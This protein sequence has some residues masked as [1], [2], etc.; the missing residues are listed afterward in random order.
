MQTRK[1]LKSF[2]KG[3]AIAD[4]VSPGGPLAQNAEWLLKAYNE[5]QEGVRVA[6]K[7]HAIA[8]VQPV[9]QAARN[10][11]D[12]MM[13]DR[14]L[15]DDT[16]IV[17]RFDAFSVIKDATR[18][19]KDDMSLRKLALH[20]ERLWHKDPLGYLSAGAMSRL[21]DH[22]QQMS[23]R[24]VVAE[25][26]DVTIPKV[27]FTNLPVATLVR[28]ASQ[29]ENQSDFDNAIA[30]NCLQGDDLKSVRARIFIRA[31]VNRKDAQAGPTLPSSGSMTVADKPNICATHGEPE[32]TLCSRKK[33]GKDIASRIANR[34]YKMA[35]PDPDKD[36]A[37]ECDKD[38]EK[39][40]ELGI[41]GSGMMEAQAQTKKGESD[42][43][44]CVEFEPDVNEQQ[45]PQ[46][47]VSEDD[48]SQVLTED[49]D[50]KQDRAKMK[51]AITASH[52][53]VDDGMNHFPINNDKF[54]QLSLKI[55][56][57]MTEV[58]T[59]W[60]GSLE[61]LKQTVRD[62][63]EKD[64]GKL[65]PGLAKFKFDKKKDKGKGKPK[66][67]FARTT[68]MVEEALVKDQQYKAAGYTIT[69][70]ANDIVN[71]VSKTGTKKYQMID[72][73][74]AITDFLYLANTTKHPAGE[75]PPPVF[76]IREGLR[77]ACP[78]CHEVNSYEMPKTAEDLSCG[79]CHA[80]IPS[81]AITAAMEVGAI[82][83]ESTLVA[84]TPIDLQDEFAAKFAKAAEIMNADV[85]T[86]GCRSEAYADGRDEVVLAKV[87]DYMVDAGYKPIQIQGQ[88]DMPS[89]DTTM[90]SSDTEMPSAEPKAQEAGAIPTPAPTTQT[91][92]EEVIKSA[93]THYKHMGMNPVEAVVQ[94]KKDYGDK[95]DEEGNPISH[96]Y[97]P[98]LVVK[99]ASEV[100]G[101]DHA[102]LDDYMALTP[103]T[104]LPKAGSAKQ[105]DIPTPKVNQ[106]QPDAVTPE[107]LGP[108]SDTKGEV[109]M[110]GKIKTQ[111]DPQGTFAD[112]GTE[113]DSD[114]RDPGTFGA[115][116]PKI[117]HKPTEQSGV[118]LPATDLG[119]DSDA[120]DNK[121][122]KK[123]DSVSKA[124][125]V[126]SMVKTAA[127]FMQWNQALQQA[128]ALYNLSKS[129][130]QEAEQLVQEAMN[131]A[132]EQDAD[133]IGNLYQ[134]RL[135]EPETRKQ[136]IALMMVTAADFLNKAKKTIQKAQQPDQAQTP[137]GQMPQD[138]STSTQAPTAIP[139]GAPGGMPG[140]K[141][142]AQAFWSSFTKKQPVPQQ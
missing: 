23:P 39:Q 9:L 137:Q 112:T 121:V 7:R 89:M 142:Q 93:M 50:L 68:Q 115:E 58:P 106:Q 42:K 31:L 110:P 14:V 38:S 141:V 131:R 77:Y 74:D 30:R 78:G 3:A 5:K 35:E 55:A 134:K 10:K 61:E 1:A 126:P 85:G 8:S 71:I 62:A 133:F 91:A 139:G 11:V 84:I 140:G 34:I 101:V 102:G 33:G 49:K 135:P 103:S 22:Y 109:P 24:S 2:S 66:F 19:N 6:Q 124:A 119:K 53:F 36:A 81:M 138:Q 52:P 75:P 90:P 92:D 18:H 76:F 117:Q 69:I 105:A 82:V 43:P 56:N 123:M 70:D 114:N 95:K 99:V 113:P 108:D 111:I 79:N 130:D 88:M 32:C 83:E 48:G 54:I 46:L 80:I 94:F 59:W 13:R 47:N 45:E 122:T 100:W 96:E 44:G 65:P 26:I 64:A 57:S 16:P 72:L 41:E 28:I 136:E 97:D 29:I 118:S 104:E 120:G 98:T 20:L 27:A 128:V 60:L 37:D 67:K 17:S 116:K 87:W 73:D 107:D 12:D 25:V 63:V 86:S 4:Q 129:G 15:P 21:R 125:S 40:N 132:P 127:E 51:A